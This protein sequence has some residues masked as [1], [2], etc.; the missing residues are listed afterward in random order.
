LRANH[1]GVANARLHLSVDPLV[2]LAVVDPN[3]T[4]KRA[5]GRGQ[6]WA[7]KHKGGTDGYT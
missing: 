6:S 1:N 3:L 7:R 5:Y 2:A 4:L